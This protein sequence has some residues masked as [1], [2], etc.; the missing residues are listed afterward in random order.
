MGYYAY[1]VVITDEMIEKG[2]AM[3]PLVIA[4]ILVVAIIVW[5]IKTYNSLVKA[6]ILIGEAFATMDVYLKRRFDLIPNLVAVVKGYAGYEQGVLK[7]IVDM[8]NVP[9]D[10][11]TMEEKI[12]NGMDAS[13]LLPQITALAE[14]YPELKA[15]RN[16]SELSAG[17]N[18]V[19]EDIANARRFYNGAVK[20]Y[21]TKVQMF[22]GSIVA[23]LFRFKTHKMYEVDSAGERQNVQ[24]SVR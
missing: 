23:V 15:S 10:S 4:G 12:Q 1:R 18:A 2:L 16:F 8:R 6:R 3:I 20:Q 14:N 22:P 21:N 19:E 5:S 24:V 11:M 13:Q 9:Y 17:L 7:Q